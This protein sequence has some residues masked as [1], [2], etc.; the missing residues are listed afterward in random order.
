MLGNAV[1][2]YFKGHYSRVVATD[3]KVDEPWL[4]YLDVRAKNDLDRHFEKLRP[5]LVLH[6]A[7]ETDLEYCETNPDIAV[8]TN[9]L[10]TQDIAKLAVE[11]DS[12]LVYISTAGVFDGKKDGFYTEAD[13]PQPI[14][15]YG[16]TKFDGENHVR[17]ICERYYVIRAGWMVGGGNGKDRKFVSKI[18]EQVLEN[19]KVIRAVTDRLGTPTYTHDFAENLFK[20]LESK[21]YGTYHMV[22]EGSG[23][24]YDVAK[25]ILKICGRTD[26]ELKGVDSDFFKET[27]WAPRPRS[28]MMLNANLREMGINLMRP[29][30]DAL[31]DYIQ[32][33][34]LS[35]IA[36]P[37]SGKFLID[38]SSA[39]ATAGT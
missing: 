22:C 13:Q 17:D 2:P 12:E 19:R 25:E 32:R 15:V 37:A 8:A 26:I 29:W 21:K 11:Y 7:A 16:Q 33:E 28:E 27:Y 18:L 5:E 4:E 10:A 34:F 30:Q 35:A 38:G 39:G 36:P 6:L 31:R 24:R 20:L 14:M 3:K 23:S 9:S 1:Y